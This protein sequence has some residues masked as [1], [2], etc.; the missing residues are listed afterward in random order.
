MEIIISP[1]GCVL[2]LLS[3][4]FTTIGSIASAAR[5]SREAASLGERAKWIGVY[6]VNLFVVVFYLCIVFNI[7][8]Q[9][10]FLR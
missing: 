4:V 9:F 6:V 7:I 5:E 2:F 8:F 3:L 10:L 1:M